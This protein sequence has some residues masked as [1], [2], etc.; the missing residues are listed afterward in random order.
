MKKK[1]QVHFFLA[2]ALLIACVAAFPLLAK[3]GLLNTRGG[4][5]SPFLLQRLQQLETAVLDGHFP[6]RWMPD[7][8]Y[9][10]GYP[11]FNYYAPLS[12][13]IAFLFR[14]V[15]FSYVRAI[16]LAQLSGFVV[17][18]WG[19]F[20]LA[21]RWFKSE[22][23]GLLTAVA[24]TVAPFHLVNVYVRGDSLAEFWAMAFY[25]LVILA[26]D[27]TVQA[28]DGVPQKRVQVVLLALAYAGLILSHNISALIFSPFLIFYILLRWFTQ[29]KMT[30]HSLRSSLSSLLPPFNAGVLALALAAWFFVPALAETGLVQ[31]GTVTEGYF[32]YGTHFLGTDKLPLVQNSFFFDFSVNG[33]S[34][35]RMGLVQAGLAGASVIALVWLWFS[36]QSRPSKGTVLFILTV[37]LTATF[38]TLPQSGRLWENVPLLSFTQFPWRFLS[39]QA[40]GIALAAGGLALLPGRKW[41]VSLLVGVL[42]VSSLGQLKTDHLILSDADVTAEKLAQYEW[43]TGNIGTTV[44]AEYL[45]QTVQ[46]RPYTSAWLNTGT[47]DRVVATA[48]EIKTAEVLRRKAT[49]QVWQVE[50]AVPSTIRFDTLYWPGWMAKVDGKAVQIRPADGSGL[51]EMDIAPGAHEVELRLVRTLVRLWAEWVSLTAVFVVLWLLRSGKRPQFKPAYV[52]GVLGFAVVVVIVSIWPQAQREND[53]L[54]WDFAQ[55]GYLHHAPDGILFEN[56][57]RLLRYELDH[58]TIQAGETVTMMLEWDGQSPGVTLTLTSPAVNRPE[59]EPIPPVLISQISTQD[60]YR[61]TIPQTAAAGLYVPRL[62]LENGR[63]LTPSGSKRGELFLQPIRV[64]NGPTATE[65][66]RPFDVQMVGITVREANVLDVQLAWMTERPLSSNYNVALR[67]TDADGN[68]LR[69]ADHQPGYGYQPSSGWLPGVWS[70][71]WQAMALPPEDEGHQQ[72]FMLVVQLYEAANPA[73]VVLTR[74]LGELTRQGLTVDFQPTEPVFTLPE[75][76]V[77]E[78]AVFGDQIQLKGY[79]VSQSTGLLQLGLVWQAISNGRTDYMRFVHLIDP[80]VV[81]APLAQVD[82]MPRNNSYPTSQWTAGEVI[83][84]SVALNLENVPAGVYQVAVG[85]YEVVEGDGVRVTA[86]DENGSPLPENRLLLPMTIALP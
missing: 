85:F 57:A 45:P 37:V 25:P 53:T 1:T 42:M 28:T 48:G 74:R 14:L 67:L 68:F 40:F 21:R 17:A 73:N 30:R 26:A 51:I 11:F 18:A 3:P 24:Y 49:K 78:T 61:L 55:M 4:G 46:P 35:F 29:Q 32:F 52:V 66:A 59:F 38:M 62:T 58:T 10:Y 15:G 72:P 5:D 76:I 86:V 50:T 41:L 77:R 79:T 64:V 7:A 2:A 23:A 16:Q 12:I 56:G 19:M 22:W 71:D 69:L 44:S 84:D 82:S 8:N 75:G 13:Y 81:S 83:V 43:F 20:V 9:G 54:N 70:Y 47:R 39:V 27:K 80:D 34:A 36:R 33:R 65:T 6:V 60:R 63:S 31:L